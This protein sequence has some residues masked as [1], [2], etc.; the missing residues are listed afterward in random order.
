MHYLH[1]AATNS[2]DVAVVEGPKLSPITE[3]VSFRGRF[4]EQAIEGETIEAQGKVELVTD[5]KN[6]SEHYR[7]IIGSK[8]SDYMVLQPLMQNFE[9]LLVVTWTISQRNLI[10]T[11]L[12]LIRLLRGCLQQLLFRLFGLADGTLPCN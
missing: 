11:S 8:P 5:K 4:C 9:D 7:L 6:G 3:V 1:P 12:W 10:E 2:A